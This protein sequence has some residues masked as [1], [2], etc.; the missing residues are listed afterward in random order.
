MSGAR[1][2]GHE[3]RLAEAGFTAHEHDLSPFAFCDALEC[4]G[5]QFRLHFATN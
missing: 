3:G 2:F 1:G 4:I 5:E